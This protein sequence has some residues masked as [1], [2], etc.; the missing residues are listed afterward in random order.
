[1]HQ[2]SCSLESVSPVVLLQVVHPQGGPG[3]RAIALSAGWSALQGDLQLQE[4]DRIRLTYASDGIV[5]LRKLAAAVRQP[6]AAQ[7][8]AVAAAASDLDA[9]PGE[10]AEAPVVPAQTLENCALCC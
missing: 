2:K 9:R 3:S 10:H 7:P 5:H 8:A 1:M 4:G 6:A